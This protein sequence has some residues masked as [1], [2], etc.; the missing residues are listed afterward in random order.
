[1]LELR[2]ISRWAS[3][4]LLLPEGSGNWRAYG[5]Y[6]ALNDTTKPDL[7]PICTI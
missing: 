4:L 2:M 6:R 1:M 3:S 7:Y 5:D